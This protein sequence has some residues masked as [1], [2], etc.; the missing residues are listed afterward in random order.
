MLDGQNLMTIMESLRGGHIPAVLQEEC[1]G[2]DPVFIRSRAQIL[3]SNY[4]VKQ[5]QEQS[6]IIPENDLLVQ[7]L[8]DGPDL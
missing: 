1:K 7:Q 5:H 4:L 8:G 2:E 3:L 6:A